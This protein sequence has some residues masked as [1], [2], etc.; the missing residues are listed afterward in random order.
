MSLKFQF[1]A[2]ILMIGCNCGHTGVVLLPVKFLW[3]VG[4]PSSGTCV[5][6]TE[7]FQGLVAMRLVGMRLLHFLLARW[8]W[9]AF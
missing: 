9:K 1:G 5:L 6:S 8:C 7:A 2:L 3:D 4:R